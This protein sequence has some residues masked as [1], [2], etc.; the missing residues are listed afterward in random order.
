MQVVYAESLYPK[1]IAAHSDLSLLLEI[2]NDSIKN[3]PALP[4][5]QGVLLLV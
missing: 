1:S 3:G 4:R 5:A 2:S